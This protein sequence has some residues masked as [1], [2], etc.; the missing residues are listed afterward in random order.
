MPDLTSFTLPLTVPFHKQ[1]VAGVMVMKRFHKIVFR[2]RFEK[3]ET[4]Q[5]F[6]FGWSYP[7]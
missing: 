5:L 6:I 1:R 3:V 7:S 4:L 2:D